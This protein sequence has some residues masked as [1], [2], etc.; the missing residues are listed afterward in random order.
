[1][2]GIQND[3]VISSDKILADTFPGDSLMSRHMR[4]HDWNATAVGN[5]ETWPEGLKVPLRMMLA[6][7]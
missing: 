6:A 7:H 4:A 2:N 5:P 3:A 1:M